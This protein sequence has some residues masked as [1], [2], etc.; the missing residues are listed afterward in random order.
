MTNTWPHDSAFM[1]GSGSN[2]KKTVEGS[3]R[4]QERTCWTRSVSYIEHADYTDIGK[5]RAEWSGGNSDDAQVV[6]E[7]YG[8]GL[9]QL[10]YHWLVEDAN[11]I[12]V[13]IRVLLVA[14]P[15]SGRSGP[16][17]FF[18]TKALV[19]IAFGYEKLLE[20]RSAVQL[21]SADCV[22]LQPAQRTK[23]RAQ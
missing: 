11:V 3:S 23:T 6:A 5:A 20:V 21:P 17:P 10:R 1:T 14:F 19:V 12:P 13:A 22:A 15:G 2:R 16:G 7:S 9:W 8:H 4:Y 18:T